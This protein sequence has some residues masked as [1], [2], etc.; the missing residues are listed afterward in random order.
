MHESIKI[1]IGRCQMFLLVNIIGLFIFLGIGVI[2]SRNRKR[3]YN[4]NLFYFGYFEFVFSLVLLY[5]FHGEEQGLK[6]QLTV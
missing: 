3:I 6:E 5:I 2:F 1:H 4:G